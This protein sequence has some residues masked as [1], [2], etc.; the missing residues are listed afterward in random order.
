MSLISSGIAKVRAFELASGVRR[1]GG[2]CSEQ[3]R[4]LVRWSFVGDA[5]GKCFQVYVN[6]RYAGTTVDSEQGQMVVAMPG[7]GVSPVRIEVFA[8]EAG[9]GH[10]D[11]HDEA[12]S[13]CGCGERVRIR[14]LR[15]QELA[16]DS[17]WQVYS[18]EGGGEVNYDEAI[19][20]GPV[21]VWP[22]WADKA[23]FGMSGFGEGDLGY[24]WGAGVGFGKGCFGM[25]MFGVDADAIEWV[26]GLLQEG[27]Y[28]FAV[29][30]TA[31]GGS[32]NFGGEVG[33]LAV[34]GG[35][36]AAEG[37]SVS[38]FDKASNELVLSVSQ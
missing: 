18:D 2:G 34:K 27:V 26:S 21:R 22:V 20:D 10:V 24:E 30:V 25:G 1:D 3:R 5:S 28:R 32:E 11:F 16:V 17:F 15:G 7:C 37:I 8:V 36:A 33:P 35:F 9:E 12:S 29:K 6:G 14:F 23:G 19:S 4:A 31:E 13:A 38:S